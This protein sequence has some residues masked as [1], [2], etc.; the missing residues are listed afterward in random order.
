M[1][2]SFPWEAHHAFGTQIHLQ[3]DLTMPVADSLEDRKGVPINL[4]GGSEEKH[5]GYVGAW[6]DT[7]KAPTRCHHH[8]IVEKPDP[9]NPDDTYLDC[10]KAI[11]CNVVPAA[12]APQTYIQAAFKQIPQLNA[13]LTAFAKMVAKCRVPK[14]RE[15]SNRISE[16]IDREVHNLMAKGPS[17]EYRLVDE[18]ELPHVVDPNEEEGEQ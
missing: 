16:A 4:I 6:M 15:L 14:C 12:A 13:R 3:Q 17:A 10:F 5:R 7:G 9:E 8:I 2:R 18:S 11:K 1:G